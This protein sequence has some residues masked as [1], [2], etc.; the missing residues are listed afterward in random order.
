MVLKLYFIASCRHSEQQI[1]EDRL[2]Y[3]LNLS[4][5]GGGRGILTKKF[6]E[7]SLATKTALRPGNYPGHSRGGRGVGLFVKILEENSNKKLIA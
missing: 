1:N 5:G 6:N 3:P 7:F 4:V 2:I